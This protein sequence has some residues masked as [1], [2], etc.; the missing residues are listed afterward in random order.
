MV[1]APL[2]EYST[3]TCI[4]K[5]LP[6]ST[7]GGASTLFTSIYSAEETEGNVDEMIKIFK[8]MIKIEDIRLFFNRDSLRNFLL[9]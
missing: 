2:N 5:E 6:A 3:V 7:F 1:A 9:V 8:N 4:V